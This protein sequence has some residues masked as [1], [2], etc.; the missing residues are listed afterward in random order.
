MHLALAT[1]EVRSAVV[2]RA[3]TALADGADFAAVLGS[4]ED[5]RLDDLLGRLRARIGEQPAPDVLGCALVVLD[6]IPRLAERRQ[7]FDP[8]AE[9]RAVWF[10]EDLVENLASVSARADVARRIVEQAPTLSLRLDLLYRFR[11]PPEGS[12]NPKLDVLDT[13]VFEELR[14]EICQEVVDADPT[15]LAE[16]EQVLWLVD[17]VH[18]VAGQEAALR[19][20]SDRA[21]LRA[22]LAQEGS[23]VRPLSSGGLNLHLEPLIELAGQGII[24]LLEELVTDDDQLDNELRVALRRALDHQTMQAGGDAAEST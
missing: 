6:V 11:S 19:R 12:D 9:R 3:L 5:Q 1:S 2:D 7:L 20:L 4:V 16:Q 22:T 18:D 21:V 24:P 14:S 23:R 8:D 13:E 15:K 17:V 10:V